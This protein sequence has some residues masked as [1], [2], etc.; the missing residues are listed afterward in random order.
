[1]TPTVRWFATTGVVDEAGD[2]LVD[3]HFADRQGK[4]T[5]SQDKAMSSHTLHSAVSY[6]TDW[7]VARALNDEPIIY[8]HLVQYEVS[9]T[10]T[11]R[12]LPTL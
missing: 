1:M 8:W 9:K 2:G 4:F 11:Y 3:M 5:K 12:R 6:L 10:F 7:A